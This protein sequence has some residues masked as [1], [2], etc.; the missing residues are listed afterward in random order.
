MAGDDLLLPERAVLLHIGP[1]KTGTTTLQG[2]LRLARP[3]LRAHGVVYAGRRRQH[4]LAALAVTGAPGLSGYE[5]AT[6]H[7]W[8]TLV[9]QVRRARRK[10]VVVSSE[11]FDDA[12]DE[13]AKR[14]VT[15]LGKKRVHVVV[16]L[17]PLA[18]IM[19]SAWQQYVQNRMRASYE[20]WL[21]AMLLRP[22]Y[23]EPTSTFWQRHHHDVL[24][25]RWAAQ[26]GPR[27]LTVIV[28]EESD[29]EMLLRT[30]EQMLGLPTGFL[31][32][33]PGWSNRSLSLA[34][35]ELVRRLN[36]TFTENGWSDAAYNRFVRIG[37]LHELQTART[38][39][40]GEARIVTPRWALQRAAEIGA[41]AAARIER[42]GVRIIG[43]L[44]TLG[45]GPRRRDP[46]R[47][48]EDAPAL[49]LNAA[50]HAVLGAMRSADLDFSDVDLPALP[51]PTGVTVDFSRRGADD[52][53]ED[54]GT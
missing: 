15:E 42:T 47:A 53:A 21:E 34:E 27:N 49:P 48:P 18:K 2:A 28:L 45:A 37:V 5:P 17:R 22:P 8:E 25:E 30:F 38:P 54:G 29:P 11:Y 51:P 43:D 7:H 16:T 39:E 24:V 35:T 31:V 12:D 10:R 26:V 14:V 52:G 3:A 20:E 23:V 19:P 13:T 9:E 40:P 6:L 41:A 36:E 50:V 32:P 1:H 44:S 46:K 33:E 4:M